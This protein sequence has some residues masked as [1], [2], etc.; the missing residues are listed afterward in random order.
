MMELT[1]DQKIKM[2]KRAISSVQGWKNLATSV[3]QAPLT[4]PTA[5]EKCIELLRKI[6]GDRE[7]TIPIEGD[8]EFG[9]VAVNFS[10]LLVQQLEDNL[11]KLDEE[12]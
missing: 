12:E 4:A 7:I 1:E 2:I 6:G 3:K 10:D 11:T 8:D 5:K 9:E